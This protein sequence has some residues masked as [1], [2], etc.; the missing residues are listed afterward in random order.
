[1]VRFSSFMNFTD[2]TYQHVQE[3]YWLFAD[4]AIYSHAFSK[5]FLLFSTCALW[6]K[7]WGIGNML[8]DLHRCLN[9][10]VSRR[11][12]LAFLISIISYLSHSLNSEIIINNM[13][14]IFD[15]LSCSIELATSCRV[16]CFRRRK[17]CYSAFSWRRSFLFM[18][19]H[20]EKN[21]QMRSIN[22]LIDLSYFLGFCPYIDRDH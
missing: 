8:H 12:N 3:W 13:I 19:S 7:T 4:F 20:V 11:K 17:M 15:R 1:M 2:G 22:N 9:V 21:E 10:I 5:F 18:R 14:F 6:W 16:C